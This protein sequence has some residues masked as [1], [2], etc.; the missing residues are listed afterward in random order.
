MWALAYMNGYLYSGSEGSLTAWPVPRSS[1]GSNLSTFQ[2]RSGGESKTYCLVPDS[3]SSLLFSGN[4]KTIGMWDTNSHE[5]VTQLAAHDDC[6]WTLAWLEDRLIS[7]SD[8]G[9]VKVWDLKRLDAP[10]KTFE[11][12]DARFLSVAAGGGYIFGGTQSGQTHVWSATT[13]EHVTSLR[14]HQWDV[15]QL[16]YINGLLCSGSYDH[17]IKIWDTDSL[18]CVKTLTG[19]RSNIYALKTES[20]D[21]ETS[22]RLIS[23]SGDKTIKIWEAP[24]ENHRASASRLTN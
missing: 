8:D 5:R 11:F 1:A 10:L 7:G 18:T 23:G 2:F 9:T 20:L 6:V 19:H 15:W 3:R 4:Y 21:D 17:T 12:G 14:G 13:F 24:P 16:S 22:I